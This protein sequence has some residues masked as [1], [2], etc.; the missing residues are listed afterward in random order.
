MCSSD[1]RKREQPTTISGRDKE[2][3]R[4]SDRLNKVYGTRDRDGIEQTDQAI[5]FWIDR[6]REVGLKLKILND[7]ITKRL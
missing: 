6:R 4:S 7:G 3:N 5:E 2:R 1:L